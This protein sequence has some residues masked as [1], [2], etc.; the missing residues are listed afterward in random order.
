MARSK[1]NEVASWRWQR[2]HPALIVGHVLTAKANRVANQALLFRQSEI[3]GACS[4]HSLCTVLV[5]LNLARGQALTHM[6]H[7]KYGLPADVWRELARDVFFSGCMAEDLVERVNRLRLPLKLTARY[8]RDADL[9]HFAVKNLYQGHLTML[10]FRSVLAG[11]KTHHW[12][13][14]T[15]VSGLQHGRTT[16]VDTIYMLDSACDEIPM[17]AFNARLRIKTPT[18]AKTLLTK[19]TAKPIHWLYDSLD[20][21]AEAVRLTGA[22]CFKRSDV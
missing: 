13:V 14:G 12:A 19:P 17:S 2:T 4:V 21:P 22:V 3:D 11:G 1:L 8:L 15:S 20:W 10:S 18:A 16:T 5:A 9:D 6:A 7:R